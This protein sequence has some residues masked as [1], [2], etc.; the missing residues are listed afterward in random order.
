MRLASLPLFI[1]AR[2]TIRAKVEGFNARV[3]EGDDR[4][5]K[6]SAAKAYL[7]L[8]LR[9]L[10]EV[11]ARLLVVGGR[12]GTGKSSVAAALAPALG[13][14][15]G[16][17]VLRSDVIRKRLLGKSPAD[18]LPAEAYRSAVSDRV[19]GTIAARARALAQA[20]RTVIADGVY[21][22]PAQQAQIETT[23]RQAGVPFRA[24]WLEAPDAMLEQRVAARTGEAPGCRCAGGP[25]PGAHVDGCCGALTRVAAGRALAD[26]AADVRLIWEG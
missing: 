21:G 26:V 8:A 12:S 25:A 13:A 2:A 7:A 9:A 11:P 10:E 6:L 3:L 18:R 22:D 1:G 19:F 5:R 23:A 4:A 16:A 15:P 24:V 17:T 14:M 20:G